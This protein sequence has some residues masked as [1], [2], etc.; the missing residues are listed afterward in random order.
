MRQ[1]APSED[2]TF[3]AVAQRD[4]EQFGAVEDAFDLECQELLAAW[5]ERLG[6]VMPFLVDQGV[7]VAPQGG[8]GDADEPPRL[9]QT[10]ARGGVRS[11]QQPGEH[12]VG[13][14][15]AGDEPPHVAAF[16][17]GAV[18]G[19]A[20]GVGERVVGHNAQGRDA[21]IEA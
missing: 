2:V 13:H 3:A 20:F 21:T 4:H 8:V 18:D 9:H 17:D 10:D 7:D 12:L 16:G 6:G 15:L 19:V 1:C 14:L 5:A 11:G